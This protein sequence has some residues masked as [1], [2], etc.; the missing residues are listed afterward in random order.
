MIQA[1]TP[2]LK[3][4][5]FKDEKVEQSFEINFKS[6]TTTSFGTKE[7]SRSC[8]IR[9][10]VKGQ[11]ELGSKTPNTEDY[12]F[13][14]ISEFNMCGQDCF[15]L[16]RFLTRGKSERYDVVIPELQTMSK[17][18]LMEFIESVIQKHENHAFSWD[19]TNRCRLY[20]CPIN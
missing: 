9:R 16:F 18:R 12:T 2:Q 10:G 14:Y 5:L 8:Y 3:I 4:P 20:T 11:F 6:K 1:A 7:L 19:Y 17:E 15:T 13:I